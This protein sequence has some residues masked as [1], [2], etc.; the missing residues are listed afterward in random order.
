MRP[1]A[2]RLAMSGPSASDSCGLLD[3]LGSLGTWLRTRKA[4]R[5]VTKTE[6]ETEDV[7]HNHNQDEQV[8]IRRRD[9]PPVPEQAQAQPENEDEHAV[10]VRMEE[11]EFLM[12][13]DEE[14]DGNTAF[15]LEDDEDEDEFGRVQAG[16]DHDCSA[17]DMSKSIEAVKNV[18]GDY[19]HR[20]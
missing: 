4:K 14:M 1:A 19:S 11:G 13:A 20:N 17:I 6:A 18:R 16:S 8:D 2:T 12:G 9:L 10:N 7:A 3:R 5:T 15:M